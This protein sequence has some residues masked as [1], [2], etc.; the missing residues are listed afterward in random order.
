METL[1]VKLGSTP[2]KLSVQL[3]N[4]PSAVNAE[5]TIPTLYSEGGGGGYSVKYIP[6][7]LSEE[8]KQTARDNIDVYSNQQVENRI[9]VTVGNI[10][11]L[12]ELI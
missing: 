6:Q 12:L 4:V 11:T 9:D 2:T 8:Q 1:E 10:K 5:V 7:D 3:G